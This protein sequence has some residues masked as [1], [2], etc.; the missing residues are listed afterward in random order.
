MQIGAAAARRQCVTF[1]EQPIGDLRLESLLYIRSL[2][3]QKGT[4]IVPLPFNSN[5]ASILLPQAPDMALRTEKTRASQQVMTTI[6]GRWLSEYW[7]AF[8]K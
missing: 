1:G 4:S 6:G 8:P 7:K 3:S 5:T 2:A